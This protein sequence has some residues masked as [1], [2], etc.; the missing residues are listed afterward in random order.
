VLYDAHGSSIR[1]GRLL[2]KGGEGEVFEVPGTQNVAKLFDQVHRTQERFAK[3]GVMVNHVPRDPTSSISHTTLCW[4]KG[5]LFEG[6]QSRRSFA[7]FLM[8][9]V[10]IQACPSINRFMF[11]PLFQAVFTW[12]TQLEI[13]AN[14]AGGLA[15][16]HAAGYIFG[17][18]N[19]KNIHVAR[20]CLVTFVDCDSIQVREP[21]KGRV[22]R[23]TVGMPEYTAPELQN[24]NFHAV[25]R[26]PESDSFAL[27][28]MICQLMLAG[29]HPFSGG[30][31]AT[32]EENIA[33]DDSFFL[34]GQL[35][36]GVP[37]PGILPPDVRNLLVRCFRAGGQNA[38]QR[39][40]VSEF[41]QALAVS[42]NRISV[43]PRQRQH[44][45]GSHLSTC[46][47]CEHGRRWGIDLYRSGSGRS[48]RPS[49]SPA[50]LKVVQPV[51]PPQPV[52]PPVPPGNPLRRLAALVVLVVIGSLLVLLSNASPPVAGP[53]VPAAA[54]L[55]TA[56][57]GVAEAPEEPTSTPEPLPAEPEE[58]LRE[59]KEAIQRDRT[60]S[61][62]WSDLGDLYSQAGQSQLATGSYGMALL[63]NGGG[64]LWT[65]KASRP[66]RHLVR[67][68]GEVGIQDDEWAGDLGDAAT[69]QNELKA[70]QEL[71]C[72]ASQ[73]D[74]ADTEWLGKL[75]PTAG[76]QVVRGPDWNWGDQDGGDGGRGRLTGEVLDEGWLEVR[77]KGGVV[78]YYRWGAE[79]KYDLRP[80]CND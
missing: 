55:P 3:L 63:L 52:S 10:D 49:V 46:P 30:R 21:R 80:I 24:Q 53:G 67:V 76:M 1:V 41:A 13:A 60:N 5:L 51:Y 50:K 7:G 71:Y 70:G 77:W 43:C 66:L 65:G 47:W 31:H 23:C 4:P 18:L 40:K 33:A 79:S 73:L 57:A 48:S 37:A 14:L 44:E 74:R 59:T 15:A 26:T 22:F 20:N 64:N 54:T 39:P 27:A 38:R 61:K 25:N 32:R 28:I 2:G 62:L 8:P 35:P 17:D 34:T 56:D 11:P 12:R 72:L 68:M 36:R 19:Y 58:L 69:G 42:R 9:R 29:N 78:N 16:L 75:D 6:S 45:F